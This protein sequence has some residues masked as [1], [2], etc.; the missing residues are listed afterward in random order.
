MI[1]HITKAY[2]GVE[3]GY[4]PIYRWEENPRYSFTNKLGCGQCRYGRFGEEEKNPFPC[5][6]SNHDHL[7]VKLEAWSLK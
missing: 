4:R 6:E 3:A 5:C 1:K 2:E 7:G